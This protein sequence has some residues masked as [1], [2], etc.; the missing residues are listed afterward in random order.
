MGYAPLL[1][2][3]NIARVCDSQSDDFLQ[4]CEPPIGNGTYYPRTVT[5]C[6]TGNWFVN[7]ANLFAPFEQL[8]LLI[9]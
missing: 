8:R 6:V 3:N 4:I 9:Q 2:G 5:G 7:Q 1:V